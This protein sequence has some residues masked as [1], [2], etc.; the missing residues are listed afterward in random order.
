MSSLTPPTAPLYRISLFFGPEALDHDSDTIQC[1]FNVKKRSWKAGIQVAVHLR[2]ETAAVV[3]DDR[4]IDARL[5]RFLALLPDD[6]RDTYGLRADDL[7]CV[8]LAR[9]KLDDALEQGLPQENQAIADGQYE[10]TLRRL[11]EGEVDTLV[12]R[13]RTELDLPAV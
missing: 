12:E 11:T 2:R 10:A 4:G 3:R 5:T 9:L 13:I 6:E 8:E 1:V 7:V